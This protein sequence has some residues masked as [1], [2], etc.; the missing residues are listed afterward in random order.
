[1]PVRSIEFLIARVRSS[2]VSVPAGPRSDFVLTAMGGL[3]RGLWASLD[4][5]GFCA[6]IFP[7]ILTRRA[8]TRDG[9]FGARHRKKVNPLRLHICRGNGGRSGR[10]VGSDLEARTGR[11]GTGGVR[12]GTPGAAG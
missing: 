6:A 12:G 8:E 5:E 10:R 9:G 3:G 4:I 7:L 1:M 2:T 11:E